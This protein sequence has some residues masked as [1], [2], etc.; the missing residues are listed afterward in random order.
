[1]KNKVFRIL[2]I[3]DK[4]THL[5][6]SITII[7]CYCYVCS[8]SIILS[9]G[10]S[11]KSKTKRNTLV[12]TSQDTTV[13]QFPHRENFDVVQN[14]V[15]I[16]TTIENQKLSQILEFPTKYDKKQFLHTFYKISFRKETPFFEVLF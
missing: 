9:Y 13:T 12:F 8:D 4:T 14:A 2:G 3:D 11:E 6:G 10:Q 16:T 15:Q 1:M 7:P 5:S